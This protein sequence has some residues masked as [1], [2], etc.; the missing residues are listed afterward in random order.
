MRSSEF[1]NPTVVRHVANLAEAQKDKSFDYGGRTTDPRA[2]SSRAICGMIQN[3]IGFYGAVKSGAKF[4][5]GVTELPYYPD[6]G[7]R[8]RKTRLSAARASGSWAARSP[9]KYTGIA[10]FFTYLSAPTCRKPGTR[11]PAICRSPR[12]L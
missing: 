10:K 6:V 1:N 8:A 4:P 7:G 2:S 9:R 11:R 12:R 5:F 3:S